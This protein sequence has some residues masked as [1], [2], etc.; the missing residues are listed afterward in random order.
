MKV[1]L[2]TGDLVF[3]SRIGKHLVFKDKLVKDVLFI[4]EFKYNLLSVSQ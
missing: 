3:I 1:N 4:L 2:P